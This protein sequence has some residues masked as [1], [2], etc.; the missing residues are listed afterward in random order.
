MRDGNLTRLRLAKFQFIEISTQTLGHVW[1]V[2]TRGLA[3]EKRLGRVV[4]GLTSLGAACIVST[5]GY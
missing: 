3:E 4:S 5:C 2:A 1:Q